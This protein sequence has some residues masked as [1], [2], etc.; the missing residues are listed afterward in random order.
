[1]KRGA[2]RKVLLCLPFLAL[3]VLMLG[4]PAGAQVTTSAIKGIVSDDHGPLPGASVIAVDTQSG[5][6]H[7]A[8]AGGD[9]GYQIAGLQPG[10]FEIKVSS[11]AYKEQS[12]TIQVLIG[13]SLTVDFRLTL[14]AV[15]TE[16]VTVIGEKTQLLIDTRSSAISTNITPQQIENLPMN[17]RNFLS[18]A[19]LAPGISATTDTDAAGQ[20]FGSGGSNPKL[21]NVFIDGLSYKNDIIQGGAFMQDSSRGNPF[22]QSAVQEYQVLTQN[23]KAEYEK[24]AAAVI[25]AIT[26]SGGND[27]HGDVFYLFQDKSMVEQDSFA[28]ARG[29]TKAPYERN[30][31]GVTVGGPI[32]KDKLHFFVS[33]ERN[34]RD[35]VSSVFRG[36]SYDQAPANV[37]AKLDGYATGSLSAPLDSKL[38][39]GKLTYQ[40]TVSQTAD[41]S[42]NRRDENEI[43][44]FGG[45]RTE[46]GAENF[47]VKTDAAVLRH[48]FV[49]GANM[50][51][52]ASLTYQKQQWINGA[53]DASRAHE[54]YTAL[55]DIGSKDYN[56]DLQQKKI[57]LRDD[58]TWYTSW[59]GDHTV[60]TGFVINW[61]KYDFMK[62]AYTIPYYEYR[63]AENWQFPF[64]ARY[65]FGDPSLNFSNNQYG[66]FIQDDWKPFANFTVNA[67]VRW[68][69]ETNML[70]N[71]WVTP[72]AVVNG[73]STACRDYSQPVGGKTHWCVS[74]MFN[75]ADYTSTGSNRKSYTGAIQPRIGFTWD[76]KGNGE[77]V[78]FGGWGTYYDRIP[79]NDIYD[80]QFRHVWKQYTFCFT[81]DGSP[82]GSCPATAVKWDP[83]YLT[84]AGLQ[85]LINSGVTGG[86]EIYLLNKDTHPP[87]TMQWTVG[88]RQQLG[89]WLGGLSYANTRGFNGMAWSF[90]T[91]P[92][93]TPFNDRWG[94][95]ISIPG[96][97]FILR[98]YDYRQTWYDGVFL[99]LDKPYSAESKWGVNVAYSYTKAEQQASNDTGTAFSFDF[100]PWDWPRF[101]SQFTDRQRLV[102]S[103]TVGLPAGFLVSSII[104]L[105]SGAPYSSPDASAG[106]DKFVYRFNALQPAKFSFLGIKQW[107]Y[108]SVDLRLQWNAPLSGQFHVALIGEAFNV[109]GYHN[110]TYADWVS[111]FR[112]PAGETNASFGKPTGEYNTRRY[113]IGLRMSF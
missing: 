24:A 17:N 18:Y 34:K 92:E 90:G 85:G 88:L 7:E 67:G 70:N 87:R 102:A 25:T 23:Y 61:M 76:P 3:A 39:F 30:Q 74:D 13:Q 12:R 106:W 28:K 32:M 46:D 35:V 27:Y 95:W 112:P 57:G 98:N 43:R 100:M 29:D 60:K 72:A 22:P 91:D 6:R 105:G 94:N 52:E 104:T 108:R 54:N 20:T 99:T 16:N 69:Y 63:S 37:K 10:T 21:V 84:P 14:D 47:S 19:A 80:E 36:P 68:D 82:N 1:M 56:Q 4:S 107:A 58:F 101:Q 44:G 26:K 50:L 113:Q 109:L 42:Y 71:S 77:T 96:Y 31:Y 81:A 8:V 103:G 15:F 64:L 89:Q 79:L 73:L 40:P 38:Y 48:Q 55:L 9:G 75:V 11:Q 51:N 93:G 65:G 78:V 5:F 49:A 97:G 45:Q 33:A 86:P 41:F 110:Y 111:G 2:T 62:A 83:S 53:I 66:V 59:M